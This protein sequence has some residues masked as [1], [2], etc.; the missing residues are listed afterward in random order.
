[1]EGNFI[2][3]GAAQGFGKEF[4][5]R[6]LLKGGRVLLSDKNKDGG[7]ETTTKFQEEF[8]ADKCTFLPIDVCDKED[9][10]RLWTRAEEFLSGKVD[11]L[12][13]NAGVNPVLFPFDTVM[14]V[15]MEGVL[16]GCHIFE[17]KRSRLEGGKGGLIVNVASMAGILTGMPKDSISYE[18]SKHGVV[19][20]TRSFGG[21]KVVKKTGIK[22]VAL[23]PWFAETGILDGVDKAKLR[24]LI[25]LDF[26]SVERVGEAFE[27]V[28]NDQRTG[29]LMLIMPGCPLTYYPDLTTPITM[30][31][32]A[33]SW[34]SGK[35]GMDVVTTRFLVVSFLILGLFLC[36]LTHLLLSSFGL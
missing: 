29:S 3:T 35:L 15:N 19:D 12:V 36:Y 14:K 25:K 7:Q 26:V 18:I 31:S 30:V 1:M 5:R 13:N 10:E 16:N 11:V 32:L 34:V 2:V 21:P 8:G 6:V 24:K 33:I 4:T 20:I 28:V 22:H 17:A 9:W 23:C 27:Q